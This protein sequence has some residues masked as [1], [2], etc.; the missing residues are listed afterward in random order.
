MRKR[1]KQ[2]ETNLFNES[3]REDKEFWHNMVSV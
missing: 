3:F 2:E 1:K